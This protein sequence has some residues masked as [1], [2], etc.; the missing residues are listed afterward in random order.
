M[1]SPLLRKKLR[2]FG[3]INLKYTDT[4]YVPFTL[5]LLTLPGQREAA[6]NIGQPI[7]AKHIK[8]VEVTTRAGTF[9][10]KFPRSRVMLLPTVFNKWFTGW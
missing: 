7:A 8:P 6:V 5:G 4:N 2:M 1:D 9:V 3:L 10:H